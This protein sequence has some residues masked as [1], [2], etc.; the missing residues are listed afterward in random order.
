MASLSRSNWGRRLTPGPEL[1]ESQRRHH[2]VRDVHDDLVPRPDHL[3]RDVDHHPV[4]RRGV[5]GD[6]QHVDQHIV[7]EGLREEEG[8]EHT[9][10]E[11]GIGRKSLEGERLDAKILQPTMRQF[12]RAP[13]MVAGNKRL[14]PGPM[15]TLPRWWRGRARQGSHPGSSG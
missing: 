3:G 6:R 5:T 1:I 11:H 4:S 15:G 2:R 7:F 12:V 13:S 9:V 14:G 10:V 8:N